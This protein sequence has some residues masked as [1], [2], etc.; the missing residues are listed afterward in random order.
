MAVAV[1]TTPRASTPSPFDR[2]PIVSLVGAAYVIGCFGVV[3]LVLPY[4][5]WE[6]FGLDEASMMNQVLLM[7]VVGLTL[8]GMGFVGIQL[9]GNRAPVGTRAGIFVAVVGVLLILLITRWASL[10]IEYWIYYGHWLGNSGPTVGPILVGAVGL[11]LLGVGVYYFMDRRVESYIVML[12]EQGWFSATSYKGLQGMRVRR[13]TVLGILIIV[14]AG[15]YTLIS[16]GTLQRG[17]E[18]WA[19]AIPFTGQVMVTNETKGDAGTW[20]A[21]RFENDWDAEN[22][23]LKQPVWMS[24]YVLRDINEEVSRNVRIVDRGDSATLKERDVVSDTQFKDEVANVKNQ[25]LNPPVGVQLSPA[26]GDDVG[27][28]VRI[29]DAGDATDPNIKPGTIVT[30]VEFESAISRLRDLAE[31]GKAQGKKPPTA[32]PVS[33]GTGTEVYYSLTLLPSLQ[34]TLPLLL[35][36]ATLWLAWR[37]VNYPVFADFLIATEAELNKVSWSTR[38][39]LMQDTVVVLATVFLMAVFLFA[40]DQA[41]SHLLSWRQIGVIQLPRDQEQKKQI[42][43]RPW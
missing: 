41:W 19:I 43:N 36:G 39:R 12:D 42:E 37:I 10:W 34:Y 25:G 3:G 16:Q 35:I 14:G 13:G 20:L 7:L 9:L 22:S 8:F 32:V 23:R 28:Y 5:W 38:R 18:N 11:I 33:L 4:L 40:M 24:R 6:V 17:P 27:N 15:I 26:A 29:R 21:K 31:Q 2:M 30:R 1:K